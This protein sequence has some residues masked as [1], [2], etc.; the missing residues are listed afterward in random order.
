MA[1]WSHTDTGTARCARGVSGC[2]VRSPSLLVAPAQCRVLMCCLRSMRQRFAAPPSCRRRV[3]VVVAAAASAACGRASGG[4]TPRLL[5]P[6]LSLSALT[7]TAAA[8]VVPSGAR[9]R[10]SQRR[11]LPATRKEKARPQ[12]G[13]RR[14]RG[15]WLD[16]VES[17]ACTVRS[18]CGL[19]LRTAPLVARSLP[20]VQA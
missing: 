9:V 19:G 17:G 11:P 15:S 10:S 18:M 13:D 8:L 14:Q 3:T 6:S 7:A 20:V 1:A 16:S 4:P 2:A 5:L 12:R